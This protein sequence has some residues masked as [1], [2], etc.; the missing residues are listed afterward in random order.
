MYAW[1]LDSIHKDMSGHK[2][3]RTRTHHVRP[4]TCK[5]CYT[6]SAGSRQ[7]P[8]R[9]KWDTV[10]NDSVHGLCTLWFIACDCCMSALD[11]NKFWWSYV[12]Q[13]YK[14]SIMRWRKIKNRMYLSLE[15]LHRWWA[16]ES[17]LVC[18]ALALLQAFHPAGR[19]LG[20]KHTAASSLFE[21]C[22]ITTLRVTPTSL[23]CLQD[24]WECLLS[25]VM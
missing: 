8:H 12:S 20:L 14:V 25:G 19:G 16:Q 2:K 22:K 15:Q 1:S 5:A 11:W 23:P 24:N 21:I 18:V 10:I 17:S 9:V 13:I 7:W 6:D 3:Y 4:L